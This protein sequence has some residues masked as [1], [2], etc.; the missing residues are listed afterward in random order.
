ML[1]LRADMEAATRAMYRGELAFLGHHAGWMAWL[2]GLLRRFFPTFACS[3]RCED[4]VSRA[5]DAHVELLARRLGHEKLP[6]DALIWA[7]EAWQHASENG[8]AAPR[9][10][11]AMQVARATQLFTDNDLAEHLLSEVNTHL[12]GYTDEALRQARILDPCSGASAILLAAFRALVPLLCERLGWTVSQSIQHVLSHTLRGVEID[13][14]CAE[15]GAMVLALE[16]HHWLRHDEAAWRVCCALPSPIACTQPNAGT[17]SLER[18][19]WA[20]FG[21][22]YDPNRHGGPVLEEVLRNMPQSEGT[23]V[24]V[25]MHSAIGLAQPRGYND[26]A[27][28]L[29]EPTDHVCTNVPFLARGKQPEYLRKFCASY[30]NDARHDLAN[31]FLERCL[32][33]V[34]PVTGHVHVL[35]PQNWLFLRS[36]ERQRRRLL[37]TQRWNRVH[38]CPEGAFTNPAAAGAFVILLH[39]RATRPEAEHVV[40]LTRAAG[41][42][43]GAAASD[44][45]RK[46]RLQRDILDAAGARVVWEMPSNHLP[47]LGEFAD[48]YVGL[49]TGDDPR[50]IQPFWAFESADPA[51]WEPLQN[52]PTDAQS[53]DG[54][55]WL[56]RWERGLGALHSARGGRPSQGHQALGRQGIA[57]QRVRK[58]FAFDYAGTRF[59]QNIAVIVPRDPKDFDAIRAFCHAPAFEIAVRRLDQKLNV[60]NRT[61]VEVPFDRSH[62]QHV[63]DTAKASEVERRT[64]EQDQAVKHP[65]RQRT[66]TGFGAAAYADHVHVCRHLGMRWPAEDRTEDKDAPWYLLL[67]DAPYAQ[68]N[69]TVAHWL[70]TLERDAQLHPELRTAYERSTDAARRTWLRDRF[71]EEHCR[72]FLQHPFVWHIWDGEPDGFSILVRYHRLTHPGL[73]EVIQEVSSWLEHIRTVRSDAQAHRTIAAARVL[74]ARLLD[75][76]HGTPPYDLHVRWKAPSEQSTRWALD[77]NDGIRVHLRP[78]LMEPSMSRR[79]FGVLR[80]RPRVHFRKDRGWEPADNPWAAQNLQE[81]LPPGARVNDR[82]R[83]G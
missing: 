78:F 11:T 70:R 17:P 80:Y 68:E 20:H 2:G 75:I 72:Y 18:Q 43:F 9:S 47:Q 52:A 58:I 23:S 40:V 63:A 16:A 34:R 42:G 71:F 79:G 25:R 12:A 46:T 14:V 24:S 28:W 41:A 39:V 69:N 32:E 36:Y 50:Y 4:T 29:Q 53:Q 57:I 8:D 55:S 65:F 73:Q 3:T 82:H 67:H 49:Q 61:L 44:T 38:F 30:Y 76:L 45:P 83:S 5:V 54:T 26:A 56:V 77:V 22:L 48:A 35:M 62:W 64:T 59:H 33:L 10:R 51:I 19:A 66:F 21:T 1:S 37:Q 7:W 74:H 27:R 81:G 13:P 15:V 31:V 6:S 60:T